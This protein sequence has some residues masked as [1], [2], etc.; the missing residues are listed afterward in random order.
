MKVKVWVAIVI[1][2]L[3]LFGIGY[4]I[5]DSNSS[6]IFW[7]YNTPDTLKVETNSWE[8]YLTIPE[9]DS[10]SI[11]EVTWDQKYGV[12]KTA[13]CMAIFKDDKIHQYKLIAPWIDLLIIEAQNTNDIKVSKVF[14]CDIQNYNS[15][16]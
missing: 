6:N 16:K 9:K 3:G 8:T 14:K 5:W 13:Y 12:T 15:K 11:Y 2:V 7:G 10:V 4:V 1:V